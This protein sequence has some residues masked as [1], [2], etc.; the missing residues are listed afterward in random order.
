MGRTAQG[1]AD[2]AAHLSRTAP[3][4]DHEEPSS[5]PAGGDADNEKI[6]AMLAGRGALRQTADAAGQLAV[7]ALEALELLDQ[8]RFTDG[9]RGVA[10]YLQALIRRVSTAV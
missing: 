3:H 10:E 9:L 4:G 5:L 7:E 2:T 1:E 6:T 8:N